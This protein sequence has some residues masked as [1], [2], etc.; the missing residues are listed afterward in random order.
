[1]RCFWIAMVVVHTPALIAAGRNLLSGDINAGR[2]IG[3]I[4]LAAATVFFILKL[5]GAAFLKFGS[6]R[7]TGVVLVAAVA[8]MHAEVVGTVGDLSTSSKAIPRP[9]GLCSSGTP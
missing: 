1:M 8:L 2:L 6:D 7:R 9:L 4:G 3:G 5:R